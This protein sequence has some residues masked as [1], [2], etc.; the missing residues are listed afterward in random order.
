MELFVVCGAVLLPSAFTHWIQARHASDDGSR[1][2]VSVI[3]RWITDG[4]LQS[5]FL[6]ACLFRCARLRT[7]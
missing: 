2:I 1:P 7:H 6:L 3:Q 4:M 5:N